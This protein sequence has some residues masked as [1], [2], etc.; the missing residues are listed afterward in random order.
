MALGALLSALPELLTHQYEYEAGDSWHAEDG[1]DVCSN[2]SRT[3]ARDSGFLC[4]NRS[5]TNM[6]YLLLIGA[7]VLLGIGATPV[8]PLGVSYIDDHVRRKDS[9]L[10]IGE[11]PDCDTF[12][13]MLSLR[14]MR[15]DNSHS[16]I[17]FSAQV[18]IAS[19]SSRLVVNSG[20]FPYLPHRLNLTM[21]GGVTH[22]GLGHFVVL[23]S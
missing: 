4:G 17:L 18:S 14:R 19:S 10:Y 13:A 22:C 15:V 16:G 7:Q 3:E 23:M 12:E 21:Q 9:S 6:M 5:N 1:R 20:T 2:V 11:W 8:Q